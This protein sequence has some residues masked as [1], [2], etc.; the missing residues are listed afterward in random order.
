MFSQDH[1]SFDKDSYELAKR[2]TPDLIEALE[3]IG[4]YVQ[5]RQ[6]VGCDTPSGPRAGVF[7][8][9][10]LGRVA[11]SDRVQRPDQEVVDALF[12]E[13]TDNLVETEYE[14]RR[15]ALDD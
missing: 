9:G 4:V 15:R 7:V 2:C 8:T 14:E 11:F 5:H 13:M 10:S 12:E 3:Q 1:D 6:V